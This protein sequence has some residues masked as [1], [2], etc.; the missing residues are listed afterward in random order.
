M[1]VVTSLAYMIIRMLGTT[2]DSCGYAFPI[3]FASMAYLNNRIIIAGNGVILISNILRLLLNIDKVMAGDG[4]TLVVNIFICILVAVASVRVSF[5]LN[6]FNEENVQEIAHTAKIQQECHTAGILVADNI[7]KH[8]NDAM[9]MMDTLNESI[10]TSSFSMSNIADSTESTAEAIQKQAVMCQNINEHADQGGAMTSA[11][12]DASTKVEDSVG[13]GVSLVNDLKQQA[14]TVA[15]ASATVEEVINALTNKVHEVE[16]FVSTIINISSQTNLLALNASIEA[17]RAGE[18]GKGFAVV[19]EEIR[20]LSEDT[21]EASNNITKIIQELNADTTR[22]NESIQDSVDSVRRQNELM[23]DTKGK[24]EE[25]EQ[26]VDELIQN[27]NRMSE[28]MQEIVGASGVIADNI[29]HLSATSEEVASSSSEGLEQ[30]KI[31]VSE[32]E[33]C[34]AIFESI[35]ML[36]EDLQ[37]S[38]EEAQ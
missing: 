9:Q 12:I 6:K 23:D 8:F 10:N 33:K 19:A 32:V 4:S 15:D 20:K 24:F 27:I 2:E 16:S 38:L 13:Q 34:R 35:Y 31:T 36:A 25:V 22:A 11:M 1:L 18:A 37:R 21:Q 28:V 17:A 14:D 3:L 7:I 5:L 26:K 30:S 29:S